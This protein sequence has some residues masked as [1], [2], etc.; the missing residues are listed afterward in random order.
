[1]VQLE[2]LLTD[3]GY[4]KDLHFHWV[5][6]DIL[7]NLCKIR[8][9]PTKHEIKILKITNSWDFLEYL[10]PNTHLHSDPETPFLDQNNALKNRV[11]L[12]I[13]EQEKISKITF[14]HRRKKILSFLIEHCHKMQ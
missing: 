10:C 11:S 8:Q 5:V 12:Y 6:I 2:L 13:I 9:N 3:L 14:H 1:M 4:Y 7:P